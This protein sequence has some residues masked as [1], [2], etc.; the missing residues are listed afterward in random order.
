MRGWL[1]AV[2][3]AFL[4]ISAPVVHAQDPVAVAGAIRTALIGCGE[5]T[6][7]G[8]DFRNY[9]DAEGVVWPSGRQQDVYL[10]RDVRDHS[11][12]LTVTEWVGHRRDFA[13]Y[14]SRTRASGY[15]VTATARVADIA[16]NPAVAELT[17]GG[18]SRGL[19]GVRLTCRHPMCFAISRTPLFPADVTSVYAPLSQWQPSG[20]EMRHQNS[21]WDFEVCA[22]A[23]GGSSRQNAEALQQALQAILR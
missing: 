18:F 5:F 11:G 7:P 10:Y 1:N 15:I 22:G 19:S 20:I 17:D 2:S 12:F 6:T 3:I 16:P 8:F 13:P 21:T 14:G 4:S 23:G 9:K